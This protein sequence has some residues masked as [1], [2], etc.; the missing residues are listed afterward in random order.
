MYKLRTKLVFSLFIL[1]SQIAFGQGVKIGVQFGW[2]IPQG[3]VF[4]AEDEDLASGGIAIEG[5]A[6][7]ILGDFDEKLGIG[8]GAN[9]SFIFGQNSSAGLD[10][11]VYGLSVYGVKGYYKFFDSKVSPYGSLTLGLSRF[12]TP[13][14]TS[15][16]TVI[17]EGQTNNGLGI[18]PEIGIE[19]GSFIMSAAYV[20]PMKYKLLDKSAGILQI[21]IGYRYSNL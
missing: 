7:Y 19:L 4:T 17:V 9:T 2:G 3:G 13:T 21:S 8:I 6:L 11:G 20:V 1:I 18:R 5:E 12:S 16:S 15:G 10:V 14:I